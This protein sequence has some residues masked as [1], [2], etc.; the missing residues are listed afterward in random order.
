MNAV[1][2][3]ELET[4]AQRL[5]G[6]AAGLGLLAIAIWMLSTFLPALAWATI[7][8]IATWPLF[9]AV[10]RHSGPTQAA[11]LI[12]ALVAVAV[13]APLAVAVVEGAQEI[14]GF[15]QWYIEARKQGFEA[16]EWLSS[17]PMI[18]PWVADWLNA[19]L[20]DE[21]SPLSGAEVQS[22]TEWGQIIGRQALRRITTLLFALLIV[23]FMFRESDALLRQFRV[24]G[25]RLLGEPAQR[26]A[27][28]AAAAVRGTIDGLLLI[29]IGEAVLIGAAYAVSGVPHA[30]LLGALTG[31]LS[32]IPFASPLVFIGASVW[33]LTQSATIAAIGLLTF[34][35]TVVFIADHFVRPILIGGTIR[36]PFIWVLLGILGGIESFGLLGLFL[37]PTLLAVLITLWRE[38]SEG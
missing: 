38:L 8:T 3:P 12:T 13:L 37:G 10:R 21:R 11:A 5:S 6:I 35:S 34:G 28:V 24:V 26:L 22:L 9:V 30:V 16:P 17:L 7:L 32:A 20:Q 14:S 23:F 36:L 1:Q 19:H 2:K 25:A 15:I 4:R 18:G 33:L 29:G 31:L 27:S